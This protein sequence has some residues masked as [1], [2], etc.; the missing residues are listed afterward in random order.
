M[1]EKGNYTIYPLGDAA[2]CV[3]FGNKL[4]EALFEQASRLTMLLQTTHFHF[5]TDI[6]PAYCSVT[7]Y[8]DLIL[9]K[10][11]IPSPSSAFTWLCSAIEHLMT[12]PADISHVTSSIIEIPVCYSPELGNDLNALALQSGITI[13]TLINLHSENTYRVYMMGFL[14]GFA[15]MGKTPDAIAF[16][17][18]PKPQNVRAGA[19]GVAGH[20]TGI[21]PADSPGGWQIFGYTPISMF[22]AAS[23]N[24]CFLKPN[25]LV[26]F[27]PVSLAEYHLLKTPL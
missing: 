14:P 21:Y 24:P 19:V 7:V 25:D 2:M 10:N 4:D 27:L 18:K 3:S 1:P 5:I 17:R 11:T 15:Y 8:Y 6:I 16:T 9:Y 20:Q 12:K 23:H 22:D 13:D 26:R